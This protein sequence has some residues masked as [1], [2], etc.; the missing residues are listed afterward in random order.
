MPA[1]LFKKGLSENVIIGVI[2]RRNG[3][4]QPT[5]RLWVNGCG[6]R[7]LIS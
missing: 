4:D 7:G 2:N 3:F 6:S 5:Q 1:N